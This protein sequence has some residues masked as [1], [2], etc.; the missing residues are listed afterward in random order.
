MKNRKQTCFYLL[1]AGFAGWLLFSLTGC[2]D[3]KKE[4]ILRIVGR[5]QEKE[6]VFPDAPEA[7]T[8]TRYATDTVDYAFREAPY[9]VLVYVDSAGC[10]SCKLQLAKWKQFIRKT[11]SLTGGTVPFLFVIHPK[12][13]LE[14]RELLRSN[15]FDRPV[16]ID[17]G[18]RLNQANRFPSVFS[19]QTFLLDKDNRV[20]VIGNP[21]HNLAIA[22]LYL[23]RL[24]GRKP[25]DPAAE[26]AP[27]TTLETDRAEYDLGKLTLGASHTQTIG[28]RN[29]GKAPFRLKGIATSCDCTEARV[30]WDQLAP[31]ETK[32]LDV[33]FKAEETG[34]F[35]R[36]LTLYGNLADNELTV[37]L[38][39]H[40]E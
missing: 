17:S 9:K 24:A 15:R 4:E 1:L 3:K 13:L 34:D 33:I 29:T 14:I 11:D 25:A 35:L 40:V 31:G 36:T 2:K 10:T 37:S 23:D 7:L 6:V 22:D 18:D 19:F 21:V 27:A 28:V 26:D 38:T 12:N 30:D 5:W 16:C 8:F 20:V 39:G 32:N